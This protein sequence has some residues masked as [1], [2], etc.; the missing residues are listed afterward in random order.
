MPNYIGLDAHSKTCTA[1]VVDGRGKLISQAQF[2]TTEKNLLEFMKGVKQ[3]RK[4][5]FEEMNLS[6]WLFVLLKD[7]VD[8]LA[9]AHPPHLPKQRGPKNDFRDAVRLAEELR[10]EKISRVHHEDSKLWDL[11]VLVHS[12]QDF[13]QDLIRQKNRYKA[14]LRGRGIF[15]AG[16]AVFTDNELLK[17][18]E[19]E[20]D[21]FVAANMFN[22]IQAQQKA[23]D[24]YEERFERI[25]KQWPVIRKLSTI[26]G[27]STIRGSIIAATVCSP[28]RF[29]TKHKF[30]AYSMLVR[31]FDESD[32][33]I[34]G[35]RKI[36]GRVQL[37]TVFMG[38]ATAVL[39]GS[40]GLRRY[41]DRLRSQGCCDRDA[42]KAVARRIAAIALMIMKTGGKYDDL[43]E[44]KRRRQENK[45]A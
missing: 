6:Q 15:V 2:A 17:R 20:H 3:P 29:S 13:T 27:I 30:W 44:D 24:S 10:S 42:K 5:A 39:K 12:Y 9:I 19:K 21:Q 4:L 37:K 7:H 23:K 22:Q 26:P 32:G 14:F 11:R 8:D 45:K 34:Y 40:S 41:Y 36:H 43:H 28:H 35:A 1:V 16:R 31:Y 33:R 18:F 38:A 25:A